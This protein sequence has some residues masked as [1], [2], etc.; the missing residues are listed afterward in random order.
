M[1]REIDQY[2]HTRFANDMEKDDKAGKAEDAGGEKVE[3]SVPI[4]LG[5]PNG[6]KKNV[7]ITDKKTDGETED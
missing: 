2:E 4:S 6:K 5:F 1:C 7:E 3:D